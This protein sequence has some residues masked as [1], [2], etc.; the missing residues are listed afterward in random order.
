M[1]NEQQKNDYQRQGYIVLNELFSP[2][3]VQKL[4]S[5]A[6][7]IV[8]DFDPTSTRSV[9]STKHD[10]QTSR[11]DYFLNSDDK[12]RCFLK[13][14]RFQAQANYSKVSI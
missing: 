1:L 3:Q 14:K 5:A 2:A 6:L 12:I 10:E 7:A 8:D 13:R 9:F 11:D 4:Q